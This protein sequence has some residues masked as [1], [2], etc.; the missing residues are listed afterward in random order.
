MALMAA[1]DDSAVLD[2]VAHFLGLATHDNVN[3][4]PQS[5]MAEPAVQEDAARDVGFVSR[6]RGGDRTSTS[7]A[8]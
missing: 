6:R 2:L 5:K 1:D 7:S 3:T 4:L 8:A